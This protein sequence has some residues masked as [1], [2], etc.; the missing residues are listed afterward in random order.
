MTSSVTDQV[1]RLAAASAVGALLVIG[2]AGV[3]SAQT[4]P[5]Q[6]AGGVSPNNESVDPGSPEVLGNTV[7]RGSGG[8]G[9]P[10]T[11]SDVAG[12]VIVGAAAIGA[13]ATAV[14]ASRRRAS[15]TA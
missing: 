15:V 6:H 13:G 5:D 8:G 11:G 7:T 14:A 12:L 4:A 10:L 9:L 2:T 3:A 1:R